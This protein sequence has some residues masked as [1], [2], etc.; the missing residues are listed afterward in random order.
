MNFKR[1]ALVSVALMVVTQAVTYRNTGRSSPLEKV[2][3]PLA[4]SAGVDTTTTNLFW[5]FVRPVYKNVEYSV[6]GVSLGLFGLDLK[7]P[8]FCFTDG[9]TNLLGAIDII[10]RIFTEEEQPMASDMW[11]NVSDGIYLL[12]NR[13][14][15]L[16]SGLL[17]LII[18]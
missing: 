10:N 16:N 8:L 2:S 4:Q 6:M 15:P 1:I 3:R 5:N 11:Q 17:S 9:L 14:N 12:D 18:L 13:C 7:N